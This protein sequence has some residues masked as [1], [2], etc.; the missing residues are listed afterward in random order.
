MSETGHNSANAA[1]NPT[2]DVK[3]DFASYI[4]TRQDA[5]RG[6]MVNEVPNYS[7]AMD[8]TLRQRLAAIGPVRSI[9][10]LMVSAGSPLQR[11]AHQYFSLA[12]NPRQ[13]P[14][15]YALGEECARRLGI[16]IPQIYLSP[17]DEPNAFTMAGDDVSPSIVLTRGI[18]ELLEPPE[19]LFVIGHECGHIHNLHGV[20]NTAIELLVNPT[21]RLALQ[22]LLAIGMPLNVVRVAASA[23]QGSLRLFLLNWSRCAE[24]TS[25]RAGL[26]C[27]GKREIAER[28]LL[29]FVVGKG[30]LLEQLN[31]E[32]YLQQVREG[33]SLAGIWLE[34]QQ[35][36]PL[37]P[38]R[39]E[40]LRVFSDTDVMFLWRP[41]LGNSQEARYTKA[42]ADQR[43]E[44]IVGAAV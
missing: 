26:I 3:L 10:Q 8:G 5:H 16:G 23:F 20:Y 13:Y 31:I 41:E 1:A 33:V 4:Q 21:A 9:A 17:I 14:D 35:T 34:L 43:C 19:L 29:K 2:Q 37:I 6:Q 18:I 24:I 44:Q 7:F 38:R 15:I 36:H 30:K 27:C 22:K 12:V 32:A 11:Q 39:I 42:E 40:A 28:A 25:D